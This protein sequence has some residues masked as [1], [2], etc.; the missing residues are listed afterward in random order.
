ML[1]R[2]AAKGGTGRP[3][4]K[5]KKHFSL[6]FTYSIPYIYLGAETTPAELTLG[7]EHTNSLSNFIYFPNRGTVQAAVEVNA[8][9]EGVDMHLCWALGSS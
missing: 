5:K 8:S 6:S 7:G 9:P 3:V 1:R 4:A 2:L